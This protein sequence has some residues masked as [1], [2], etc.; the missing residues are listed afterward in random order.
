MAR[1]LLVGSIAIL[2]LGVLILGAER[3]PI[4][5][6]SDSDFTPENGVIAGAGTPADPY[7][8]AGW[9]IH[10]P[11]GSP[12]GVRIEN[13]TAPF[14]L[15]GVKVLG[16]QSPE[17]AGIYLA[18]V[19]NGA[20]E[21]CLVQ[22]SHNGILLLSSQGIAIRDTYL[23]VSGLGLQVQGT[24]PEHYRHLIEQ[25]NLV[26]GKPI[27]YYWGLEGQVL[28]GI[29]AGSFFLAGSRE[30]TVQ[31]LRV[32]EGDGAT[33]A[34]C[35]GITAEGADLFQNRGH[36]LYV[37]SSPQTQ[38]L[39]CR[40]VA[41]N[42]LSGA[43]LWLSPRSRVEGSGFYGNQVGLYINAS[44]RVVVEGA[45]FGGNALGLLVA[46]AAR[47]VEIRDSLFYQNK[48]A[49]QLESAVGALVERCAVQDADIGVQVDA[50]STYSRVQDST[51]IQCG[52]G[53]DILGSQGTF[54]RN[55]IAYSNIGI[56]FEEAYGE[57]HPTGNSLRHNLIY[58]SRDGLY[59]GHE[60]KDT[61]LQENLIWGCDRAARDFGE[62][63]WAPAGRGNWY[64]G[65]RGPDADGDGIGDE[66]VRFGG[67]GVDPAPL[68]S[69]E[70]Y[71]RI[72]GLLGTLKKREITLEDGEGHRA[73]LQVLVADTPPARLLGF[74]GV[75]REIAQGLV[76][77]FVWEEAGNYG[78][79][80][81][82][83]T[84]DLEVTFFSEDGA[85]AGDLSMPA[86]STD[87]Y[88]AR[89]P[90]L[91]AL[92]TPAGMLSQLGLTPPIFLTLP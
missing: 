44:D 88:A 35:E 55:L 47:E 25:T 24:A 12:Y 51:F 80:N 71:A 70:F 26:N 72:P 40:R 6:L 45:A 87:R 54:E 85:F 42:A 13:T 67:G 10:V 17:G 63:N 23:F 84:V 33:V 7:I 62:N 9:D 56:I 30:V 64:S 1:G 39:N 18:R 60:T 46:G 37:L 28:T 50:Q 90:F 68:T 15:R 32:E 79:W 20:I 75:P 16:A 53:L 4:E 22:E 49:V 38:L 86:G 78:L 43:L 69:R 2:G 81:R 76:I 91:Y 74:Q 66:P 77:L 89:G 36:G 8:I 65:Y 27:H 5:I 59:L 73:D 52:Y 61:W 34:F 29:E 41:N 31:G 11:E 83:V 14:V 92:E 21:D 3:G 48:T 19:E 57:A 58:R 82:G